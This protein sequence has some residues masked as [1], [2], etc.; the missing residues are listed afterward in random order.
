MALKPNGD[1]QLALDMRNANKAIKRVRFNLRSVDDILHQVSGATW[2]SVLDLNSAFHQL[3]LDESCRYIT[4][5]TTPLG[6]RQMT[7]LLFG[8]N[9][10]T[11]IFPHEIENGVGDCYCCN[12][13]SVCARKDPRGA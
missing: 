4:V 7:R 5:F 3:E 11:E 2:F 12:R 13:R 10:A 6:P 9:C 1:Y 8:V